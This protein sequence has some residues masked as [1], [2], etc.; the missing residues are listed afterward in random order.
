MPLRIRFGR[1]EVLPTQRCLLV[2]GRRVAVGSRAFDLMLALIEHRERVVTKGELLDLVWPGRV[3]EE[4][5]V[6]VQVS[7]LRKIL[8][9]EFVAT[10]PGVGYRLAVSLIEERGP[11]E[12]VASGSSQA[13]LAAPAAEEPDLL[14][15]R[16]DDL[17]ALTALVADHQLVTIVGAG[18]IGKTRLAEAVASRLQ[19]HYAHGVGWVDLAVVSKAEEAMAA[20]A[21]A[22]GLEVSTASQIEGLLRAM[23]NRR[24]LLVLDNCEHLSA[25]IAP[26]ARRIRGAC[27]GIRVLTT[28]QEPLR[29]MGEYLYRL[30]PLAVPPP[31]APLDVA[32]RFGAVRLLEDCARHSDRRFRLTEDNVSA[33]IRLCRAL[34][35]IPLAIEIAGARVTVLGL[36]AVLDR[37]DD[38]LQ[39]LRRT[40][41]TSQGRHQS[42]RATLDWSHELLTTAEQAAFRRL[43]VFAGSFGLDAAQRVVAGADSDDWMALDAMMTLVEKS[44]VHLERID[45]PRYRLLESARAYASERLA[46]T[47]ETDMVFKL[48]GQA[49]AHIAEVAERSY[50][51]MSDADWLERYAPFEADMQLA[52]ERSCCRRDAGIAAT[53]AEALRH[54]DWLRNGHWRL[55]G[56]K[57]A[58]EALLPVA[59]PQERA[60]LWN[61]LAAHSVPNRLMLGETAAAAQMW[62]EAGDTKRRYLAVARLASA[63]A[64]LGDIARAEAAV[65]VLRSIE[66]AQWPPRLRWWGALHAVLVQAYLNDSAGYLSGSRSLIELAEQGGCVRDA[67]FARLALAEA[68]MAACEPAEAV[69]FGRRIVAELDGMDQPVNLTLALGNL[70]AAQVWSGDAPSALRTALQAWPAACQNDLTA[71]VLCHLAEFSARLGFSEAAAEMLGYAN[72]FYASRGVEP[73]PNQMRSVRQATLLIDAALGAAQR[74]RLADQGAVWS[75]VQIDAIVKAMLADAEVSLT[76]RAAE[77][78]IAKALWPR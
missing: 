60:L 11:A 43:S 73:Q 71:F 21:A 65:A 23:A 12:D 41:V 24:I 6:Q 29:V 13:S 35:G 7:A 25:V 47:G 22:A 39:L 78:G 15:G 9:A 63:H 55:Q 19:G 4:A 1:T 57:V 44:L 53:T 26:I 66:E 62:L 30:E 14:V 51:E 32:R 50:W 18:G 17:S 48:H 3:V 46:Q 27:P 40:D 69:A 8:G 70:F 16:E 56:R 68:A 54:L 37:L 49:M 75:A 33:A 59:S 36:Q 38:R 74:I 28:S 76:R 10:I 58:A 5:N 64:R 72:A 67:S 61:T 31:E 20:M 42:L 34:D 52:F 45:P 77:T 2:D